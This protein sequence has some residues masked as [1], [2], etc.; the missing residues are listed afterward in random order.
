M[1]PEEHDALCR[2]TAVY[3][4]EL[5]QEL[6]RAVTP[7]PA[8]YKALGAVVTLQEALEGG[9]APERSAPRRMPEIRCPEPPQIE[10]ESLDMPM[11]P[12]HPVVSNAPRLKTDADPVMEMLESLK[13]EALKRD[14]PYYYVQV[15]MQQD[16]FEPDEIARACMALQEIIENKDKA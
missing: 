9:R 1:I 10:I 8:I 15:C 11:E 4:K 7:D 2:L 14:N 16:C 12:P 6:F 13:D 3:R 5:E